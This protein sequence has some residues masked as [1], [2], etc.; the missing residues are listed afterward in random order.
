MLITR[1]TDADDSSGNSVQ[2][3][4][5]RVL[6]NR[7]GFEVTLTALSAKTVRP[8]ANDGVPNSRLGTIE[9]VV[10]AERLTICSVMRLKPSRH[11]RRESKP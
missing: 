8:K 10:N 4:L 11:S 2:P 6:S 5:C 1:Q 9:S 3:G 7:H